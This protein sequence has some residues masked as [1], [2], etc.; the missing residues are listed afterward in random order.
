MDAIEQQ[1]PAWPP[2]PKRG[3]K[4]AIDAWTPVVIHRALSMRVLAVAR[5]RIEGA[6]AAY[7]DAVPG[8]NHRSEI[9]PVLDNGD[10][11][12]EDVARAMFP[13]FDHVPY[14]R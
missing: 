1:E 4:A 14:A 3:D 6:W 13:A 5:T 2:F 12:P 7:I 8:M 10:K 9:E 11:L